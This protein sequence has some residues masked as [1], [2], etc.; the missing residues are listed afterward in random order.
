MG[1]RRKVDQHD[2]SY[3]SKLERGGDRKIR[4][5]INP[6]GVTGSH[7]GGELIDPTL[8]RKASKQDKLVSVLKPTQVGR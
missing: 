5:L 2:K 8:P 3:V 7:Y 6:K 1:G 4:L